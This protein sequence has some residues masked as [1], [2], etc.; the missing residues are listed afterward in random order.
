MSQL[1]EGVLMKL[2]LVVLIT[3]LWNLH[4]VYGQVTV[5]P[6]NKIELEIKITIS[7]SDS[8]YAYSYL[9]GNSG[10]AKQSIWTIDL[11]PP[12][13]V[14]VQNLRSPLHWNKVI[15]EDS[16]LVVR[17]NAQAQDDI[18]AF[19]DEIKPGTSRSGF[20]FNSVSPPG[21][22]SYYS[23]GWADPPKFLPGMATDSIPGYSDLTPYGPGIVGKTVGPVL[24]P[25]PF[26]AADFLDTLASY[27]HQAASLSWVGQEGFLRQL[28]EKL[29]QARDQL[30]KGHIKQARDKIEEF[31]KKLENEAKKTE[32]DQDKKNDKKWVTSEGHALL[33]FNAEY[34]IEKLDEQIT[35]KK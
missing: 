5:E 10:T 4:E 6:R 18:D 22:I 27:K 17:W 31:V 11:L 35:K 21:I 12:N 19:K 2:R 24:P 1:D 28:D 3:I 26:V 9:I 25:D 16:S 7:R 13:L 8:D 15:F 20:S 29:D 33:K 14:K 34:L 32:K 30:S 23:E